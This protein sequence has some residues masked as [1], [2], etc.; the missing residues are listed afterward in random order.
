M[1]DRTAHD[2]TKI[3]GIWP[4]LRR[5]AIRIPSFIRTDIDQRTAA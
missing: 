2:H 4:D 3:Y 5:T 1:T